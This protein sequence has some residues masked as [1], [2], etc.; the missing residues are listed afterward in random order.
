MFFLKNQMNIT[1]FQS[2][3]QLLCQNGQLTVN[4]VSYTVAI[5]QKTSQ[6]VIKSNEQ[7]L[8]QN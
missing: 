8:C 1:L 7:L 6:I 4:I 5:P 3:C 2:K